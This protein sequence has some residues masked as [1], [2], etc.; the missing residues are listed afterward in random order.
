MIKHDGHVHTPYCPHGA[1]DTLEAYVKRA[2]QLGLEGITFTEH[3]PLPPGFS[4]PVPEKDS[5]MRW[6]DVEQYVEDIQALKAKYR[7]KINIFLGLEVDYIDGFENETKTLLNEIGPLLD[8]AILS[9]HFLEKDGKY[10]CIDYSD[11]Y[12]AG[13]I[14]VF[15][16]VDA[17][18]EAY[19]QTV[20]KSI[21]ADLGQY[22]PKRIGHITLAHKFQ[23]RF[24]PSRSFA[25]EIEEIIEL[26]SHYQYEIDYNSAGIVKPLCAETYPPEKYILKA[27]SLNV[28]IVYGSDAHSANGLLQGAGQISRNVQLSTP[29]ARS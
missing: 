20:K 15:G 25:K 29:Q 9:V 17:I 6:E 5:A 26:I 28:P 8:D 18:Y 24:L 16:S 27:Q 3:A 11:D 22:K 2:L 23:K 4:D 14:P 7:G 12:F 13:M 1:S 19:F 21:L 10:Y